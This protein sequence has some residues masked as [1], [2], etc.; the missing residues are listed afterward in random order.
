MEKFECRECCHVGELSVRGTCE[1]CGSGSVVSVE[2]L[3]LIA[4]RNLC[5]A[6]GLPLSTVGRA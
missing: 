1:L 2:L 6:V 3:T 4:E 5:I